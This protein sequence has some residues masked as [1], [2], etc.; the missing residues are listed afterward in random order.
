MNEIKCFV[1][2]KKNEKHFQLIIHSQVIIKKL[3]HKATLKSKSM[4][5]KIIQ[6]ISSMVFNTNVSVCIEK[7]FYIVTSKKL[8][9]VCFYVYHCLWI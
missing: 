6:I 8:F 7:K 4:K 3:T 9:L 5:D 1:K 2:Q